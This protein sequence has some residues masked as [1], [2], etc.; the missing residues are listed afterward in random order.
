VAKYVVSP[1]ISV[2]R[3]D[4]Y[5]GHRV[6]DHYRSHRTDR[7][8]HATVEVDTFIGR[9]VQHTLPKGFKRIRYYG[10]QATKTFAKVKG[11]MQAA[12]AMVEGVVKGAIKII[13]RLTYRQRYEQSTGRD[14]WRCPHCRGEMEVWRI[15]HPAYGVIYDEGE[16][17][18]RGTYAST[19]Q[20]A[21]P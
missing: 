13:A 17:I 4:R 10:V 16:V 18:K 8:E 1:P 3:I 2:G 20:R 6:T 9:M 7:V 14:P 11:V 12:L 15:W 5:D 21:G 19:A